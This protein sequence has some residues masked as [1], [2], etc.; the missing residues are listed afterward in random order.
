MFYERERMIEAKELS[1]KGDG[2]D[3][4]I[5]LVVG[6]FLRLFTTML[7]VVKSLRFAQGRLANDLGASA[8]L[9]LGWE[10]RFPRTDIT[11]L[12]LRPRVLGKHLVIKN[13]ID[14][15]FK[16]VVDVQVFFGG[17]LDKEHTGLFGE[18]APFFLTHH[19]VRQVNLSMN[20]YQ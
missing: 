7:S 8:I 4:M 19:T 5:C 15:H 6:D 13:G 18:L 3:R 11:L 2:H 10:A 9:P 1:N 12:P 16:G 14:H 20:Y 17:C